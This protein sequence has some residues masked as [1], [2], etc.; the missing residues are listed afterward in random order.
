MNVSIKIIVPGSFVTGRISPTKGEGLTKVKKRI[1]EIILQNGKR[2]EMAF[3][4][5]LDAASDFDIVFKGANIINYSRNKATVFTG[6]PTGGTLGHILRRMKS[7]K[8]RLIVPVGL[9][10]NSS[11]DLLQL[12]NKPQRKFRTI[13]KKI[14]KLRL[15]PGELFTEIEAIRQFA[16]VEVTQIGSGGIAGAEGAVVLAIRGEE[17]EVHKALKIIKKVQGEPAFK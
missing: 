6:S 10:K 9:E 11:T 4:E 2:Q 7:D 1:P 5:A 17:D 13:G 16:D 14:P 8:F 12:V 3:T 15:V